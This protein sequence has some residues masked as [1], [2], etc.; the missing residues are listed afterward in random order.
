MWLSLALFVKVKL[1]LGAVDLSRL[2]LQLFVGY[3]YKAEPSKF[4]YSK[5][6]GDNAVKMF[7]KRCPK[8]SAKPV[9]LFVEQ[10]LLTTVWIQEVEQCR[11]N[12]RE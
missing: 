9:L 10:Y 7:N 5:L 11:S 6:E 1:L 8:D 4:S 2:I 3:L 12:C